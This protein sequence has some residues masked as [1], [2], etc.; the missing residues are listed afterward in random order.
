VATIE[1]TRKTGRPR[2]RWK[3]EIEEDLNI[4]GVKMGVRRPQIVGNGGRVCC[5]PRSTTTVAFEKKKT[6]R[7]IINPLKTKLV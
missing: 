6:Q 2:K 4:M 5:K 7:V 3:E 1:G